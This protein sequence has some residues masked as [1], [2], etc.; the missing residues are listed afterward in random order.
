MCDVMACHARFVALINE[1]QGY[2]SKTSKNAVSVVGFVLLRDRNSVR[3]LLKLVL[4][5]WEL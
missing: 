3:K 5:M 1:H 4:Q 2:V